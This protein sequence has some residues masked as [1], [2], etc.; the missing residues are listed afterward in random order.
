MKLDD[1]SFLTSGVIE[2]PCENRWQVY[3]RLQELEIPCWCSGYQP[4]QVQVSG[5][6]TAIQIRSVV[7]QATM[8]RQ[9]LVH[10]LEACWQACGS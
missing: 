9:I 4:L 2:I 1:P 5:S 6:T 3:R 10:W 7:K 8:P